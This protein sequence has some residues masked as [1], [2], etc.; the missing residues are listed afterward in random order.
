MTKPKKAVE[1]AGGLVWD[2]GGKL[3]LVHRPR[4][5][6]WSLPKGKLDKGESL[7][8]C[9]LREVREETGYQCYLGDELDP[10]SYVDHRGRPKTVHYWHMSV[11]SGEF[12][13]ND[14][15]D[16]IRWLSPAEAVELLSYPQD[17]ALVLSVH[18]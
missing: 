12:A 2:E 8:A 16:E 7:E 15:V 10:I 13:E 17:A 18:G 1:A 6:D 11:K 3:L 9:A 14:E 5:N 4:Y